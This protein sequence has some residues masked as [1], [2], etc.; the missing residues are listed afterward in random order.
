[1][2]NRGCIAVVSTLTC[3]FWGCVENSGSPGIHGIAD[4]GGRDL[5]AYDLAGSDTATDAKDGVEPEPCKTDKDCDDQ[6]PCTADSCNPETLL[7]V[8]VRKVCSDG[9]DCTLDLC[10]S[11]S[12]TCFHATLPYCPCSKD[13]DC[14]DADSCSQE[15]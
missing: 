5:P 4:L 14:D 8:R 6:D 11:A 3:L 15:A 2:R 12:G 9:K 1:M 13:E 7:C 10:D